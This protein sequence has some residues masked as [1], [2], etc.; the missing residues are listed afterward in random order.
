MQSPVGPSST[1]P[2]QV[3]STAKTPN[4]NQHAGWPLKKQLLPFDKDHP[5][6]ENIDHVHHTVVTGRI[7]GQL[8]GV[9]VGNESKVIYIHI[10]KIYF[11]LLLLFT[12]RT[13]SLSFIL[14]NVKCQKPVRSW[15][16]LLLQGL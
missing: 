6:K 16:P 9:F 4:R 1:C 15:V 13:F 5:L 12:I 3:G 10:Y 14:L 8:G 7:Y 11:L 2:A